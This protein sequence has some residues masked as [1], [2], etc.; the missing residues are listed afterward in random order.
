MCQK[1]GEEEGNYNNNN[2]EE[3]KRTRGIE[4]DTERRAH[5]SVFQFPDEGLA[6]Q[7]GMIRADIQ[8]DVPAQ[9]ESVDASRDQVR[10]EAQ[11]PEGQEAEE[12]ADKR[13]QVFQQ[14]EAV[15]DRFRG[16]LGGGGVDVVA[17]QREGETDGEGNQVQDQLD[18][19]IVEE[20]DLGMF[21]HQRLRLPE[22]GREVEARDAGINQAEGAQKVQDAAR[23][24]DPDLEPGQQDISRAAAE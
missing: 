24:V 9:K 17:D 18:E 4:S 13:A 1:R 5:S 23:E 20:A 12:Y 21:E 3:K 14:K 22:R 2:K 6:R 11:D 19:Q 8:V 15:M 10:Q 16:R 7:V